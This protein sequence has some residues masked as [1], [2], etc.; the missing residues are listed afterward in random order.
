MISVLIPA[1]NEEKRISKTLDLLINFFDASGE[2]YEIVVAVDGCR[3][4]TREVVEDYAKKHDA[5]KMAYQEG[6]SGKGGALYRAFR[7]STGDRIVFADADSASGPEEV[8]GLA[9][10]LD[11][12]DVAWGY[13]AYYG[14][15]DR[16]P[17]WRTAIG[18]IW[19]Y[20]IMVVFL[21]RFYDVQSGYKAFRRRVL[22]NVFPK[23]RSLG[24]EYDLELLTRIRKA[25]YAIRQPKILWKHV[26][27]SPS[28]NAFSHMFTYLRELIRI[29]IRTLF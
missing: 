3:D 5:V 14:M 10:Q 12:C 1:Y 6:R 21:S 19:G 4:R 29:R 11:T 17:W 25:G 8:Y 18:K 23:V 22:E 24:I 28:Y 27:G 26:E 9:K 7:N 2:D 15:A 16:Q 20:L 13:R